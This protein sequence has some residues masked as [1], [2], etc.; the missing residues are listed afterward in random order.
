MLK[1]VIGMERNGNWRNCA[2]EVGNVVVK[3]RCREWEAGDNTCLQVEA[4]TTGF[5]KE[6]NEVLHGAYFRIVNVDGDFEF[7]PIVND[8]KKCIGF[9]MEAKDKNSVESMDF[10]LRFCS[11]TLYEQNVGYTRERVMFQF[12]KAFLERKEG[13]QAVVKF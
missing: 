11:D 1:G 10:A 13:E 9:I 2:K 8:E 4:G 5:L 6:G 3:T 12:A 7:T